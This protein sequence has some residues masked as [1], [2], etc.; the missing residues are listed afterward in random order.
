MTPKTPRVTAEH[1]SVGTT[2]N[3][4]Y[5]PV[6][7]EEII[8]F[9]SEWDN[10]YFHTDPTAALESYFGGLI[11]S[12]LHTLSIFQRLAVRGF[13]EHYDVIAGKEIRRLRFLHPVRAGDVLTG[14]V[15]IDSVTHDGQG[16]ASVVT[17][18]SL[19]NQDDVPVLGLQMEALIT[20]GRIPQAGNAPTR[21]TFESL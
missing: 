20:S 3:L 11:A 15:H 1:L 4:G 7:E 18:G 9:A 10:Q 16:R 14:S 5:H 12:G 19:W 2:V 13:F 21:P 17:T 8:R 6:S